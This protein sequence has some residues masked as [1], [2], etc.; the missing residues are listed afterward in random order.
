[1]LDFK[2]IKKEAL[3][4]PCFI[5]HGSFLLCRPGKNY[6]VNAAISIL[7]TD[8]PILYDVGMGLDMINL[9]KNALNHIGRDPGDVK[10]AVISHI[11]FD[12]CMNLALFNRIF[13][14]C[15]VII[16]HSSLDQIFRRSP[17]SHGKYDKK[18]SL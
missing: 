16:H 12:H 3:R 15:E 18:L 7:K 11:H 8:H 13:P 9:V 17:Q 2:S 14:N 5:D 6:K 1:M 4:K 10:F